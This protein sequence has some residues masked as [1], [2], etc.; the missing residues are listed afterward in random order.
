M[1]Y[2]LAAVAAAIAMVAVGAW[3]GG[4]QVRSI[5]PVAL[6]GLG[7]PGQVIR[8]EIKVDGLVDPLTR[9]SQHLT[10][11]SDLCSDPLRNLEA[12]RILVNNDEVV[13]FEATLRCT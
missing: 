9:I 3:F 8:D 1:H 11:R 5:E 12:V 6:D 13:R 2:A 7:T 10:T 4:E